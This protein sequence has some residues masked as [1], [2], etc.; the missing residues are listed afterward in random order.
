VSYGDVRHGNG[1]VKQTIPKIR[2]TQVGLRTPALVDLIKSDKR[3]GTYAFQEPR[4]RIGGVRDKRG[5]YYV[6]EGHHRVVAAIE[7]LGETGDASLLTAL[8]QFGKWDEVGRPPMG[9]GPL[10]LRS[11][12]GRLRNWVGI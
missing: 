12:W 7:I 2:A 5:V 9:S 8:L 1:K 3:N 4:G 11:W 10:P 6:I